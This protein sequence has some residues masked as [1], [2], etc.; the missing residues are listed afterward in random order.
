LELARHIPA[1]QSEPHRSPGRQ[2]L[3]IS[4]LAAPIES[5]AAWKPASVVA[6]DNRASA[7][8][9][10]DQ[11][12]LYIQWQTD[13]PNLIANAA[14]DHRFL[15]KKGGGL[16]LMLNLQSQSGEGR[17]KPSSDT[18]RLLVARTGGKT[19]A[20]L[21]KPVAPGS[22]P[23]SRTVFASPVGAVTFDL[24]RD[25]SSEVALEQAQGVYTIKVPLSLLGWIPKSGQSY[26]ADIGVLRGNG[27]QTMQ[28]AYWNNRNT[29]IVS[30]IP[31]EAL[32][33]TENWGLWKVR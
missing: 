18:L 25:V 14:T 21:Y 17:A 3:E 30:D 20:V 22:P 16:D 2:E 19:K 31:S 23:E 27:A 26:R 5:L 28:R 24:V 13:D 33:Q 29:A 7:S 9:A 15:F 32:L 10:F 1:L 11:T 6:I 8:V 4:N 12:H